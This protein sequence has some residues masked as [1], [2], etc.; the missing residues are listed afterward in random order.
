[1]YLIYILG[2]KGLETCFYQQELQFSGSHMI[3]EKKV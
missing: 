1:M 3:S 2:S